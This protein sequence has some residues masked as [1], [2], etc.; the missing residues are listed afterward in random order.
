[1]QIRK[2]PN[3]RITGI[4]DLLKACH[5][6]RGG[7]DQE[8]DYDE[9]EDD[10]DFLTAMVTM[11]SDAFIIHLLRGDVDQRMMTMVMRPTMMMMF[12][13]SGTCRLTSHVLPEDEDGGDCDVVGGVPLKM[14]HALHDV[15]HRG[16]NHV[17]LEI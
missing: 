5:L 6:D 3:E 11:A 15:V 16:L 12:M 4:L 1:M 7:Y 10:S 14:N 8:D 13:G 9:D 2:Q 17:L